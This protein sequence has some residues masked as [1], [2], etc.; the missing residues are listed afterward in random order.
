MAPKKTPKKKQTKSK[1]TKV[2][3]ELPLELSEKL[4]NNSTLDAV[5]KHYHAWLPKY[6]EL[7]QGR[8]NFQ[9]EKMVA[10]ESITPAANYQHTIFQLR[11]LHQSLLDDF[12]RGIEKT[13][14]FDYKWK[15][16]PQDEPQWWETERG[17]KKLCW[18][19]TDRLK[20]EHEMEELKMS[21]KDKLLQMETFT[22][23]LA[24]MEEKHGGMY[25]QAEIEADEPEYWRLRL[26]RQMSDEYLDRQTGLGTGN[27]KSL[28][29][30]MAA[31]P[32]K[33][34]INQVADFP[35]FFNAVLTDR[36]EALKVLNEVNEELFANIAAVGAGEM[37][38]QLSDTRNKRSGQLGSKQSDPDELERLR[39]VGI[40]VSELED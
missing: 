19:D 11:I 1:K 5:L 38:E 32:V 15:E 35:D 34:S 18:Y 22:K 24:A 29:M 13:R 36:T 33:D 28:R 6:R 39:N 21:V 9:I 16:K 20:F 17:G 40:R 12:I 27:I 37:V 4:G 8:S 30:A 25:T 31:S 10:T 23:V 3:R 14:E 2:E 7:A 26:S